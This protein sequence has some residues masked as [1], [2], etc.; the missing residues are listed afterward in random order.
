MT[1][2][3]GTAWARSPGPQITSPCGGARRSRQFWHDS[4]TRTDYFR[5]IASSVL[6]NATA[7]SLTQGKAS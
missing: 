2:P 1:P 5:T 3:R 7:A 6:M 4:G